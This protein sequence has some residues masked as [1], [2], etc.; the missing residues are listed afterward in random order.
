MPRAKQGFTRIAFET[1]LFDNLKVAKLRHSHGAEAIA[2]FAILLFHIHRF[3]GYYIRWSE[4]TLNCIASASG[5]SDM[6]I[7]SVINRCA[8]LGLFDL[9]MLNR[10]SILTSKE[11]QLR[12][13]RARKYCKPSVCNSIRDDFLLLDDS[14]PQ[15]LRSVTSVT[16]LDDVYL[17]TLWRDKRWLQQQ[18]D[19]RGMSL[20]IVCKA[21]CD[22][23]NYCQS[24]SRLHK[25]IIDARSH[26]IEWLKYENYERRT[27]KEI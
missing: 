22:F 10:F 27:N 20:D 4:E 8:E 26:F 3:G 5:S 17:H 14:C 6:K 21:F 16:S 19:L 1:D 15:H 9:G 7:N 12:F 2:I 25:N 24:I 13:S 18:A 23:R 11:I